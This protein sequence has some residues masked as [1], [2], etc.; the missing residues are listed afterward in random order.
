MKWVICSNCNHV[1]KDTFPSTYKR[2]SCQKTVQ[3]F[4]FEAF[5]GAKPGKIY[6]RD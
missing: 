5:C 2:P 6:E 4:K 3:F 1:L